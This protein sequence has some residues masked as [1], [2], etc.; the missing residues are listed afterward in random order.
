[1][2]VTPAGRVNVPSFPPGHWIKVVTAL[3]YRTPS[4][5]AKFGFSALTLIEV[6]DAQEVKAASPMDVIFLEMIIDVN[7]LLQKAHPPIDVTLRG[8]AMETSEL[9]Q[10]KAVSPIEMTLFGMLTELRD[11]QWTNVLSMMDVEPFPMLAVTRALH[12][13]N[14]PFPIEVTLS[15]MVTDASAEL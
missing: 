4:V 5:L 12:Q 15:G 13:E 3:L 1:M 7:P 10:P 11:G 2:A 8:R 9:H 6:R 14:D